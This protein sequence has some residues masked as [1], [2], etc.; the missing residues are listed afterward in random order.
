[1]NKDSKGLN[2]DDRFN[3]HLS[4]NAVAREM[5]KIK[6]PVISVE[7]IPSVALRN[8]ATLENMKRV[9]PIKKEY[10]SKAQKK[11]DQKANGKSPGIQDTISTDS[12]LNNEYVSELMQCLI[13]MNMPVYPKECSECSKMVCDTCLIKYEKTRGRSM[14]VCMHCKTTNP[15][16]FRDV[17]SKLLQDLI[18]KV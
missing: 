2:A 11:S 9:T 5:T 10:Q 4:D 17:Q 15:K 13:C 16:A 12:H 18:D 6:K 8:E 1:M 7:P 14:P 3:L